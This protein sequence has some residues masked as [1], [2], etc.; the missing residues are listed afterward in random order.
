MKNTIKAASALALAATVTSVGN[1]VQADEVATQPTSTETSAAKLHTEVTK[2]QVDDAA[3]AAQQASD[4]ADKA[5]TAVNDAEQKHSQAQEDVTKAEIEVAAA[6]AIVNEATPEKIADVEAEVTTKT[7]ELSQ[8]EQDKTVAQ[9][10]LDAAKD[11]AAP[12]VKQINDVETDIKADETTLNDTKTNLNSAKQAQSTAAQAKSDAETAMANADKAVTS[13]EDAVTKAEAA[14]QDAAQAESDKAEA[15]AQAETDV[16]AKKQSLDAAKDTEKAANNDVAAK[17]QTVNTAQAKVTQLQA[18][19]DRVSHPNV[20]QT[21]QLTQ[22]WYDAVFTSTTSREPLSKAYGS[23][24]KYTTG[25]EPGQTS[26]LKSEEP[27]LD[28]KV[29]DRFKDNIPLEDWNKAIDVRN[30]SDEDLIDVTQFYI[31]TINAYAEQ[32]EELLNKNHTGPRIRT[33]RMTMTTSTLALSRMMSAHVQ[34]KWPDT[35]RTHHTEL[36]DSVYDQHGINVGLQALAPSRVASTL[37]NL[38]LDINKAINLMMFR[39]GDANHG[40]TLTILPTIVRSTDPDPDKLTETPIVTIAP[41]AK[42]PYLYSLYI[43]AAVYKDDNKLMSELIISD[44][45]AAKAQLA[46]AKD[47]LTTAQVQLNTAKQAQSAAK[48]AVD[49][50]QSEFDDATVKLNSLKDGSALALA[51]A[52]VTQA[53]QT[54]SNAKAAQTKANDDLTKATANEAKAAETV[55]NL[56]QSVNDIT[57]NLTAK[58]QQLD[59]LKANAAD[60]LAA[61]DAAQAKYNAA[62]AKVVELKA[63][64]DKAQN[65]LNSYKN[66]G[67]LLDAAKA[68]LETLVEAEKAAADELNTA[69]ADLAKAVQTATAATDYYNKLKAQYDAEQAFNVSPTPLPDKRPG[70]S[71]S[72]DVNLVPLVN[73]STRA[74]IRQNADGSLSYSRVARSKTLPNT[75]EKRAIT[76]LFGGLLLLTGLSLHK[77]REN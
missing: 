4:A 62:S 35:S 53:K 41:T 11:A 17:Q 68:K 42:S 23:W 16:N 6:Q 63:G 15:I 73:N 31:N 59:E 25:L 71:P 77:K 26:W 19:V 33:R 13:A 29:R 40:H 58:R 28:A 44:K 20:G 72:D 66:A 69:K 60:K 32:I 54:L 38:K 9:S 56:T 48:A 1:A 18:T 34:N 3:N 74:G 51:K 49:A 10:E 14:E 5:Q 61:V 64:I 2:S 70:Y 24:L 22:D 55:A 52:K 8:A 39:D 65:L 12:H 75:G 21:I 46:T 43:D 30:L 76:A 27:L 67:P 7:E 50:A 45:D 36:N 47:E 57:A 37:G